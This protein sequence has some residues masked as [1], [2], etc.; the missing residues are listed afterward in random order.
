MFSSDTRS[1]MSKFKEN[2]ISIF[3]SSPLILSDTTDPQDISL[4]RLMLTIEFLLVIVATP[5]ILVFFLFHY[6]GIAERCI[7]IFQSMLTAFGV[8]LGLN[9]FKKGGTPQPPSTPMKGQ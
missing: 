2:I 3:I 1:N 4:N 9:C 5:P 6:P 7:V 8:H